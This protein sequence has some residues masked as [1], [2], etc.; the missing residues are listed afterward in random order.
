M[1]SL[2]E[3][4]KQ[5]ERVREGSQSFKKKKKN[6]KKNTKTQKKKNTKKKNKQMMTKLNKKKNKKRKEKGLVDIRSSFGVSLQVAPPPTINL[7]NVSQAECLPSGPPSEPGVDLCDRSS[8]NL[9]ESNECRFSD[10]CVISWNMNEVQN[11]EKLR[12]L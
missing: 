3:Q 11:F 9:S 1:R 5:G 8:A 12:T 2:P 4:P 10:A 7:A 6:T